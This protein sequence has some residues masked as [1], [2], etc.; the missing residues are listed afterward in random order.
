MDIYSLNLAGNSD[1]WCWISRARKPP[2]TNMNNLS[3]RFQMN[4][5]LVMIKSR[6]ITEPW[7]NLFIL[8]IHTMLW[9]GILGQ[10]DQRANGVVHKVI[11]LLALQ[12]N[13]FCIDGK[14]FYNTDYS[15]SMVVNKWINNHIIFNDRPLKWLSQ[16][17]A[18]SLKWF[19]FGRHW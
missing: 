19:D 15:G 5:A 17:L 18:V 2:K 6:F 7:T 4:P 16:L 9:T 14:P 10:I 11:K 12:Y 8:F 3:A 1:L 13:S